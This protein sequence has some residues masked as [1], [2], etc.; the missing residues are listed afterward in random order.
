MLVDRFRVVG[1]PGEGEREW[2]ARGLNRLESLL[3]CLLKL[4]A[5]LFTVDD[6]AAADSPILDLLD[7]LL[8]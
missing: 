4:L 2:L 7:R 8:L 1:V 5:L 6:L 3:R